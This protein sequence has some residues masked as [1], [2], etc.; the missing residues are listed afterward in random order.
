MK[1]PKNKLIGYLFQPYHYIDGWKALSWGLGF[2]LLATLLAYFMSGRYDGFLDYHFGD[3]PALGQIAVDQLINLALLILIF[4]GCILLLS[5]SRNRWT[6]L[7]GL[8]LLARAPVVL[9]PLLNLGDYFR[10]LSAQIVPDGQTLSRLPSAAESFALLLFS[11]LSLAILIWWLVMLYQV[12]RL[13]LHKS[14]LPYTL[15]FIGLVVLA[16]YLSKSFLLIFNP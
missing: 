11:L 3:A 15:L 16:E 1:T 10:Q 4:G 6:D 2:Q 8:L 9:L 12:F 7:I 14:G 5:G 13:L